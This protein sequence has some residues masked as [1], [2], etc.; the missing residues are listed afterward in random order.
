M[1]KESSRHLNKVHSAPE[2]KQDDEYGTFVRARITDKQFKKSNSTPNH[3]S[4]PKKERKIEDDEEEELSTVR[5]N[6]KETKSHQ[7]DNQNN[8]SKNT[9]Y[10]STQQDQNKLK[11]L[12]KK[13]NERLK[14]RLLK[15]SQ[16]HL[17]D[18]IAFYDKTPPPEV[19]RKKL[20][21]FR[22]R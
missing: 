22:D 20:Y 12:N 4:K 2:I 18:D 14:Q 8:I 16:K 15:N 10:Q 17:I 9:F 21:Y 1:V 6:W 7:N 11:A 13:H 5:L 19:K 3:I